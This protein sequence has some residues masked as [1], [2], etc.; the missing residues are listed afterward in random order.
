M[1]TAVAARSRRALICCGNRLIKADG[2]GPRV[3]D[4][5]VGHSLPV[6]VELID[7]GIAGLD[8]LG[9]IEG[10][11]R[12]VLVDTLADDWSMPTLLDREALASLAGTYGHGAGLPFLAAMAPLVLDSVPEIFL[13]GA[14]A[15][16]DEKALD[17]LVRTCM[18]TL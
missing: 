8:L 6:G 15:R 12:V 17:A 13:V 11:E 14:P 3:F 9:L 1:V 7:G 10:R 5:L 16:S 18:E 4:R 2:I